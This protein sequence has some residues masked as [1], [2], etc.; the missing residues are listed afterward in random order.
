MV[1][2]VLITEYDKSLLHSPSYEILSGRITEWFGSSQF[3]STIDIESPDRVKNIK[4]HLEKLPETFPFTTSV[5]DFGMDP[6]L[7]IHDRDYVDYLQTIFDQWS[8][9]IAII[10]RVGW[11]KE[12]IP[13]RGSFLK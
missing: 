5:K 9:P 8:S 4:S 6:I 7:A 2:P 12:E 13:T 1:F 10:L 11:R 3:N